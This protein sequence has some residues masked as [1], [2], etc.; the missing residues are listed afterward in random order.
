M[1]R[2]TA[3]PFLSLVCCTALLWGTWRFTQAPPVVSE[4][5]EVDA[6]RADLP[7][8]VEVR[9][10]SPKYR[11]EPQIRV[12]LKEQ[13][14]TTLS[15]EIQ[16]SYRIQALDGGGILQR[17][18]S[19][20][21]TKV[22]ASKSGL[23]IGAKTL[24]APGIE[25]IPERSPAVWVDGHQYREMPAA[26]P[27]EARRAQAIVARTYAL[28]QKEQA[29]RAAVTD[30]FA[31]TRSQ[32]YLG[33]QYRD[34][35]GRLLAGESEASRAT[36][37][38]TRGLVG[39]HRGELFCTYYCAVCGGRTVEGTQIF[40][41]AAPP[42]KSVTCDW[43]KEARLYR[44][45]AEISKRDAQK[46][47]QSALAKDGKKLGTLKGV[48]AAK[49][50]ETGAGALFQVKDDK[51]SLSLSGAAVRQ[52]LGSQGLYSPNFTVDD[53]GQQLVFSGRGH[54]HGVGLCQWGA[55][56]LAQEGRTA[57]QI[58]A[59]Y[60]RGAAITELGYR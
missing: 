10:R 9:M 26:F 18:K 55:R 59:H 43:C 44:W 28:Y 2:R 37:Q 56:G 45:Q 3:I 16:G 13:P 19:L 33:F 53:R 6:F 46:P 31:S 60:Y 15:L 38:A 11:Q 36:A 20:A 34:G 4:R 51:Q 27:E 14:A 41:D 8:R 54:G 30:L 5:A 1:T 32:K 29:P 24:S 42:L 35:Q 7:L 47:L 52:A 21:A 49:K 40:S 25:I 48:A 57:D 50:G 58:F 17:G 22:T 23:M 12:G 39:T